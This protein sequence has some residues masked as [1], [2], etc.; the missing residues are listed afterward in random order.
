MP[1]T[2]FADPPA[3][4]TI[5]FG[6]GV[7][8]SRVSV[9]TRAVLARLLAL[10][11]NGGCLVTSVTRTP[12]EQARIMYENLRIHGVGA[13]RKLYLGPGNKVIDAFDVRAP[14]AGVIAAMAAAIR[15][16][17][18]ER[19]SHHCGDPAVLNVLDIAPSSLEHPEAF[20]LAA[21]DQLRPGGA[22]SKILTPADH[23][24]AF[25]LEFPQALA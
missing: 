12:E 1:P 5:S 9:S 23:D 15:A 4:P 18:P 22:I 8:P 14:S 20:L 25:H 10:S 6:V 24:P 2:S 7:D 13:Q 16:V 19:V 21:H 11:G 17:G 3:L